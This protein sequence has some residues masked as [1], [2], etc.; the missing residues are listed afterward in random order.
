MEALKQVKVKLESHQDTL[1]NEHDAQL[2][3]VR[4]QLQ[5]SEANAYELN[6][7]IDNIKNDYTEKLD[8]I[9]Q[10]SKKDKIVLNE[11]LQNFKDQLSKKENDFFEFKAENEKVLALFKEKKFSKWRQKWTIKK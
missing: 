2:D 1:I 10:K 9:N 11:E 7:N 5:A 6:K 8:E 3:E 4:K